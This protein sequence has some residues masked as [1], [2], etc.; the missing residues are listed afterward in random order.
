MGRREG[1][2]WE[3]EEMQ[4]LLQKP[5]FGDYSKNVR[6]GREGVADYNLAARR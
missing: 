1:C 4:I 6:R 2:E 5:F 3:D